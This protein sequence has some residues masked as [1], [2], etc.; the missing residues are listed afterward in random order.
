MSHETNRMTAPLL[1]AEG[2]RLLAAAL[3]YP[4]ADEL[5]ALFS[6]AKSAAE[7]AG[8]AELASLAATLLST[9]DSNL[10]GEYNRLFSQSVAVTPYETSYVAAD[11]G[12]QL[13]RL[14]ALMEA[15]GVRSRGDEHESADHVGSELE[16]MAFLCLKEASHQDETSVEGK[17]AYSAVRGAQALFLQEHLGV[18]AGVF[19]DRL[20]RATRHP[21]YVAIA[22]ILPTWIERD[23]VENGWHTEPIA[24]RL[25][26]PLVQPDGSVQ[27]TI[28]TGD[29]ESD[30]MICPMAEPPS[31][32]SDAAPIHIG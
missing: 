17:E 12:V 24:P 16:F 4:D 22:E 8:Q 1:R 30:A 9:V 2:Y 18:W 11:K 15:F 29:L 32:E 20:R 21:F 19:A 5:G 10:A 3:G 14:A 31:A 13:G 23:L 26:L 28:E 27:S 25:H 7:A 6:E